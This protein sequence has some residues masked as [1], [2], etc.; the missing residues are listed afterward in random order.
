MNSNGIVLVM[1]VS[2]C[3]FYQRAEEKRRGGVGKKKVAG[4]RPSTT[5]SHAPFLQGLISS[6]RRILGRS[7]PLDLCEPWA[8]HPLGLP[9]Q[10]LRH[11]DC[12]TA[13][14]RSDLKRRREKR[15]HNLHHN[16]P[17]CGH[18]WGLEGVSWLPHSLHLSTAE[19]PNVDTLGTYK[20]C[21]D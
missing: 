15:S 2:R 16:T 20:E 4:T 3:F 5:K 18:Y 19:P 8:T 13:P 7:P 6:G 12:R 9:G 1:C 17:K 10:S 14:R 21:P 11:S